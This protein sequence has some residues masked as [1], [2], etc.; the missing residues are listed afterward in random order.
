[1]RR[2]D[3]DFV[4]FCFAKPEDAATFCDRL[5]GSACLARGD[6]PDRRLIAVD[7][8]SLSA[9]VESTV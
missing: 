9:I 5:V 7:G 8:S 2:D 4:V 3:L 6:E 1:M